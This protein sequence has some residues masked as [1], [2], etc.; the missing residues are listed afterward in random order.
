MLPL[1]FIW[2]V[3]EILAA[4]SLGTMIVL[5][6]RRF[7][8][9]RAERDQEDRLRELRPVLFNCLDRQEPLE[10]ILARLGKADRSGL[11]LLA[12]RLI[13]ALAGD[14]R[15][16]LVDLLRRLGHVDE[17]LRALRD[18]NVPARLQ[19][20][21]ELAWF[22][23]PSVRSA[24]H[25]ALQDRFYGVRVA[26]AE[27]L[28]ALGDRGSPDE[29]IRFL[30]EDVDPLPLSLR[31]L[32]RQL[33][34]ISP[35]L[36][37]ELAGGSNVPV[38]VLA[39]DALAAARDAIDFNLLCRIANDHADKNARA[40]GLRTLGLLG[41]NAEER[42]AA[43]PNVESTATPHGERMDDGTRMIVTRAVRKGLSDRDWEVR[44]QA[45]IATQR[46]RLTDAIPRLLAM[47]GDPQW[48]VRFRCTQA[49]RALSGDNTI[50]SELGATGLS[51]NRLEPV[52]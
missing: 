43:L 6:F 52:L 50:G 26:A 12:R 31:P 7:A 1:H 41:A 44:T 3:T 2:L 45:V 13:N 46:M 27:S 39:I 25:A 15:A 5:I 20:A 21:S 18:G 22:D 48:W 37:T 49:L 51:G 32:F 11:V 40:A 36:M 47:Q 24:L 14:G 23:L 33:A 17:Q 29:I 10:E 16:V 28:I 8:A 38:A 34:L 35:R 4:I 42:Q 9:E 30:T 19:A